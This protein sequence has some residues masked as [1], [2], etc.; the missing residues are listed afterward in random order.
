MILLPERLEISS[1]D[2]DESET[3]S[4]KVIQAN[5]TDLYCIKLH[6]IILTYSFIK[7]INTRHLSDLS[8]DTKGGICR[9]NRLWVPD[10]LQL[11]VIREIHD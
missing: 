8:I 2:P 10:Y 4:E 3:I 9:F 6:K 5:L 11:M 7:S 1:I